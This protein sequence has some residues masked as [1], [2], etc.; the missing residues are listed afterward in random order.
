MNVTDVMLNV[1]SL[2]DK[3]DKVNSDYY[4]NGSETGPILEYDVSYDNVIEAKY[5][6]NDY[7]EG[8]ITQIKIC[9]TTDDIKVEKN[10]SG[11]SVMCDEPYDEDSNFVFSNEIDFIT[12]LKEE[13]E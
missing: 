2:F 4:H 13:I 8:E 9:F 5:G 6:W 1:I 3:E 12:W 10:I 7:E 11:S